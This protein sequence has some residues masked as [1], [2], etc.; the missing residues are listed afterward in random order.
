MQHPPTSS[1]EEHDAD[2]LSAYIDNRLTPVERL[3]VGVH[4]PNCSSCRAQLPLCSLP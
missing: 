2:L 1:Q 3:K 4:L